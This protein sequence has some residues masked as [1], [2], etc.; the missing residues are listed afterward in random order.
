LQEGLS[1]ITRQAV[2]QSTRPILVIPAG[3]KYWMLTDP[4]PALTQRI[5]KLERRIGWRPQTNL[6]LVGRLE[7]LGSGLLAIKETEYLGEAR[8]GSI[9]ERI[10]GLIA[11]Q[12]ERLENQHLNRR[13]D[14]WIL[15]RIRRLRQNLSRRLLEEAT[16][17]GVAA[18]LKKD[19]DDLLFF[20]N[21]NAHSVS[22]LREDPS[23]ERL[24]ETLQRIEETM[25]DVVETP[26]APMAVTVQLGTPIDVR[27]LPVDRKGERGDP[28]VAGLRDSIQQLINDQ[29]AQGPPPAWGCPSRPRPR[30]TPAPPLVVADFQ[31]AG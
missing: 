6:D 16:P 7:K 3:I 17:P 5:D 19:L 13:H 29:I 8:P 2:K 10:A 15:E 21:L 4:R 27:A 9:D 18:G 14:G 30:V 25:S 11:S 1:L 24:V 26:V 31:S 22:Y 28:F 20:E 23:P 12:V